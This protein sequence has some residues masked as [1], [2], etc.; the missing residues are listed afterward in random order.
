MNPPNDTEPLPAETARVAVIVPL[1]PRL[2]GVR[3]TLASLAAQT[4]PPDLVVL[5]DDGS[6]ADAENLGAEIPELHAE[7]IQVAATGPA[8]AINRVIEHLEDYDFAGLLQA[9]DYYAPERIERCLAAME[10][11]DGT[12]RAPAMVI[13]AILPVGGNGH[14]LPA[15]DPRAQFLDRLWGPGRNGIAPPEWLGAGNFAG[16][17][18]NIFARRLHLL[19]H[20]LAENTAGFAYAAAVCAAVQGLLSVID[21]PL[22][23]HYPPTPEREP[24]MRTVTDVLQGQ[25]EVLLALKDRLEVSPETRRNLAAFHRSAWRNWSG[26]RE[27]VFQQLLLRLAATVDPDTARDALQQIMRSREAQTAPVHWLEMMA[28]HDLADPLAYATALHKAREE[29]AVLQAE[30]RRLGAIAQEAQNSGWVRFGAWLGERSAR[31]VMEIEEAALSPVHPPDAKIQSGSEGDPEQIWDEQQTGAAPDAEE[32][33][34]GQ[35]HGEPENQDFS[36]SQ[37]GIAHSEENRGP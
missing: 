3:Q 30:N 1:F 32:S 31:R 7:V 23:L 28:D 35:S 20:P 16:P 21:E 26:L 22:L 9:G 29:L 15:D 13:T 11:P 6:A 14:P 12:L 25:L 2:P 18:S 8:A 10:D 27:D 17:Y 24:T 4:R 5:L 34:Q 37:T 36:E 19:A 33:S